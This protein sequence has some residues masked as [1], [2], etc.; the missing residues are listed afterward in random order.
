ML[1]GSKLPSVT[2]RTRV[3]DESLGGPNPFRWQDMTTEDYFGGK[4]VVLF[5]LPGAFTPTCSTYQLPG[6]EKGF[7]DF[8]ALGIDTIYCLSVNDSFVMNQWA[9]A[10]GLEN[11]QVI[12]D[13]SGEFTRR[14]GML[15]RKDNLGFGLRSWRYAAVVNN[16]VVEAWFEEPGLC[17]NHEEDPYGVSSPETVLNW[18]VADAQGAAA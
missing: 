1:P 16:G 3:R 10:Q 18:L 7:A 11:V 15:V 6:F 4:R 12:P 9:K 5:A 8:Q 13:G 2:F 17:D 14:V